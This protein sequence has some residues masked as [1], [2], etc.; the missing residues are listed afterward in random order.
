MGKIKASYAKIGFFVLV[1]LVI[2]IA[3]LMVFGSGTLFSKH[4]FVETYFDDSV[5]GLD[6]G[7]A[8]K[9]RGVTI[10]NVKEIDFVAS[11]YPPASDM[12]RAQR[13]LYRYVRVLFSIDLKKH[14]RFT[15]EN[16]TQFVEHGLRAQMKMQGVTGVVFL[17]LDYCRER[18]STDLAVNWNPENF[19]LPSA[20]NTLSQVTESFQ[21]VFSRL[22]SLDIEGGIQTVV[23]MCETISSAVTD[24]NLGQVSKQLT[25]TLGDVSGVV[26]STDTTGALA[27]LRAMLANLNAVSEALKTE[28]PALSEK[29]GALSTKATEALDR[30]TAVL[31]EENAGA[32]LGD[33]HALSQAIQRIINRNGPA[34]DETFDALNAL[35]EQTSSFVEELR[36]DPSRV[37]VNKP[38]PEDKQ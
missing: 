8:V 18:G 7:S 14:P 19:Y 24:L 25:D 33:I 2:L 13:R 35:I 32:V 34:L 26:K 29:A 5:Q 20:P 15:E 16:L 3:G 27:D 38:L 17:D 12:T 4:V 10:G 6:V 31:S 30:L 21:K 23:T 36:L 22:D 1:G 37:I 11:V 28:V 9:Y